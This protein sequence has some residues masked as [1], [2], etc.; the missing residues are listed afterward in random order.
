MN[1]STTSDYQPPTPN[2]KATYILYEHITE[3]LQLGYIRP[4]SS[5]AASSLFFVK[6]T[7]GGFL[8]MYGLL[9]I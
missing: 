9:S 4:S 8:A 5:S 2:L 6:K 1:A 3:T 7:D